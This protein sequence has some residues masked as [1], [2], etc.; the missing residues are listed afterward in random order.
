MW[1]SLAIAVAHAEPVRHA[2]I[3]GAN[4]GGGVLEPLK[5]AENDAQQFAELLVELGGFDEHLV[6]VLYAPTAD[7]LRG[8]LGA[9]ASVTEAYPEDLFVFYYS[10]HADA[11]GLRLSE[12]TFYFDALKHDLRAVNADVSIGVL[13]ACRAGAITRLKGG[14]VTA[15]IFQQEETSAEGEAWLTASS[16]DELAQ[17]SDDLRS[18]FFTH[19]LMSGMRGAADTGDGVVDLSELY[20]YTF[21]RVVARTGG[22]EAGAQHPMFDYDLSG[23]GGVGLTDLRNA[24]ATLVVPAESTGLIQVLRMPDRIQIAEV[25]KLS[26][27]E[28]KLAVPEGRY[29]VRRREDGDLYEIAIGIREGAVVT[30]QDWGAGRPEAG[31]ARGGPEANVDRVEQFIRDSL[32]YEKRLNLGHSPVIAGTS[33]FMIP[34]AGQFYNG[35]KSKGALYFGA[36]AVLMSGALFVPR[37]GPSGVEGVDD[38]DPRVWPVLGAMV[39]GASIAD[40][41]YNVKHLEDKRPILGTTIG[42]GGL[43]G[44]GP[45]PFHQGL[46]ADVIVTEGLSVGLDRVG[47]TTWGDGGYDVQLGSR[48]MLAYEGGK[49]RPGVFGAFGLRYGHQPSDGPYPNLT[50]GR[51]V[52]GAGVNLRYYV[53]PRYFT[54]VEGRIEYGGDEIVGV[55]GFGLGVHLGR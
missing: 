42:W 6:T 14:A 51:G 13:D 46:S 7:D 25:G 4:D 43:F 45:W 50:A 55:A 47:F 41:T 34:G 3:V 1:L 28:L 21:D 49:L 32:D 19:Y 12:D 18:G 11:N 24:S 15:S 29:L 54:E 26:G 23:S 31:T 44:A 27:S 38:L 9:H 2:V 5:Y 40:A 10:G 17:E 35:Q 20:R 16:A 33:S 8:A 52:A 37:L 48:L 22:T 30:L 36:T 53:V 39:W